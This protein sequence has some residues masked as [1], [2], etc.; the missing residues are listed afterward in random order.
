M[1]AHGGAAMP[2][3]HRNIA[4]MP[5]GAGLLDEAVKRLRQHRDEVH[6]TVRQIVE[7][8]VHR[9][10][11][12]DQIARD[13][14]GFE[15]GEKIGGIA[16]LRRGLEIVA[17]HRSEEHTSELQS[18]MRRSYAVFCSKKKNTR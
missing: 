17:E 8:A 1:L 12:I 13:T 6:R 4:E 2:E 18:L 7:E 11:E 10:L 15:R 16:C 5:E 14:C 9:I 3:G